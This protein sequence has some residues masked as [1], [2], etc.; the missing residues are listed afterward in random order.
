V[1]FWKE[2]N[3]AQKRET[4]EEQAGEI[5]DLKESARASRRH[6]TDST[7]AFTSLPLEDKV[8]N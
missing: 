8:Y 1:A 2:F 4:L 6:L 5:R 7:K 3:I